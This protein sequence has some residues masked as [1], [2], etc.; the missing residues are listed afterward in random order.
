MEYR[1]EQNGLL[2]RDK[3]YI[4][5]IDKFSFKVDLKEPVKKVNKPRNTERMSEEEVLNYLDSL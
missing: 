1:V 4:P 5:E 2:R 3:K